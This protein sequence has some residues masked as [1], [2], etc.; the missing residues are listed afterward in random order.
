MGVERWGVEDNKTGWLFYEVVDNSQCVD[1]WTMVYKVSENSGNTRIKDWSPE[2]E[3]KIRMAMVV[4]QGNERA[5]LAALLERFNFNEEYRGWLPKKDKRRR[6]TKGKK[7]KQRGRKGKEERTED[8]KER[9]EERAQKE[10]RVRELTV[11]IR[12]IIIMNKLQASILN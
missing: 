11:F 2:K 6:P 8:K 7:D 4:G 10:V 5:E 12:I 3:K 9:K 1:R